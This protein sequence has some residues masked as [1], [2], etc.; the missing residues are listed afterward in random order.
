MNRKEQALNVLYQIKP[1][2]ALAHALSRVPH[3]K[4]DK[5]DKGNE[6]RA[7]IKGVDYFTPQEIKE[8]VAYI[9]SIV[10]PVKGID[11]FT[12][13]EIRELI[14]AATPKKGVHY[15]DGA[16]GEPGDKGEPGTNAILD[17]EALADLLLERILPKLPKHEPQPTNIKDVLGLEET[18]IRLQLRRGGITSGS[19]K[20]NIIPSGTID[21]SNAVFTLPDTPASGTLKVWIDGA[22]AL[23]TKDYTLSNK[24]ITCTFAPATSIVCDYRL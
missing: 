8:I 17:H 2:L 21:G 13:E 14:A 5:G 1:D 6:G 9:I 22:R 10:K 16:K 7:P 24:T 19:I 18:L 15:D 3:L 4:G 12:D 11:Y 20:E 23:S